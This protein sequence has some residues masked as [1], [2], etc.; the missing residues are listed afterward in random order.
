VSDPWNNVQTVNDYVRA[1]E[2][3]SEGEKIAF[4]EG[5]IAAFFAMWAFIDSL[6][7]GHP[8]MQALEEATEVA[9]R[10]RLPMPRR[11]A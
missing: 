8:A 6:E 9:K 7:P 2:G 11:P 4:N 3:K 1:Q 5:C 10:T